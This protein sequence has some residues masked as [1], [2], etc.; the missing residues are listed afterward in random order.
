MPERRTA[1]TACPYG[2]PFPENLRRRGKS[3]RGEPRTYCRTCRSAKRRATPDP[4]PVAIE[5]AVSGNPPAYL[6]HLEL[7][8]AIRQLD[9]RG[10]YTAQQ[11]ADRVGC[12]RR[13]VHRVRA[14][15]RQT[16]TNS[17]TAA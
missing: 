6:H 13:T 4:D 1:Q 12:T 15:S 11:I 3:L 5:R 7:A 8:A 9:S 17:R 14:R 16:A 2:H 10:Q